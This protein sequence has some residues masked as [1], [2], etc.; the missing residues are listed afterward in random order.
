LVSFTLPAT[1]SLTLKNLSREKD[2]Q[3]GVKTQKMEII[4]STLTQ[5]AGI[6]LAGLVAV[7]SSAGIPVSVSAE[8]VQLNLP[9]N[10]VGGSSSM[11]SIEGISTITVTAA[12]D[13]TL[14]VDQSTGVQFTVVHSG[15][16]GAKLLVS[17][18]LNGFI[19]QDQQPDP[20]DEQEILGILEGIITGNIGVNTPEAR[21]S[22]DQA[23]ELWLRAQ[24]I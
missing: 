22:V 21:L 15:Q 9:S 20:E 19:F 12:S 8:P 16:L 6:F 18:S 14:V 4:M 24:G 11:D 23:I 1:F 10:Y 7:S 17:G 13:K 5:K 3:L 2:Q